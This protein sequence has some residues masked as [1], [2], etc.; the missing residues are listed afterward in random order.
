MLQYYQKNVKSQDVTRRLKSQIWS[1][2]VTI[3]LI[4]GTN[5][6]SMDSDGYSDPYVKFRSV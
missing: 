6:I 3:V 2:V 1:S 4:K 5:L